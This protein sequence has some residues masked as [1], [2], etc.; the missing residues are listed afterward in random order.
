MLKEEYLVIG[1]IT[2]THGVKGEVKVIPLTDDPQR[3]KKLEKVLIDGEE[4]AIEGC[5]LQSKRVILKIEGINS[6]EEASRYKN[7]YLEVHRED[8]APLSEGHYYIADLIGC[9]VFDDNDKELGKVYDVIETGS[10]DVYWVK[11]GEKEVLI[12]ALKDIVINIDVENS[13]IVI[14]PVEEWS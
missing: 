3:F 10:N 14:K 11:G 12:P 2:K 6:I 1:Q 8:A 7:K 9:M 5:K 13:R 4:R